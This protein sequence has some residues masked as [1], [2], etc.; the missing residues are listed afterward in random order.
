MLPHRADH[1]GS[2]LR[3]K[4]L[5][6]A[7]RAHSEKSIGD[8]ELRAAQ[9]EAIRDVV[10][11][12]EDCGLQVVTDGEFRRISYWEQFVRLTAGL[13]VRNAVFKFHD[14]AGHESDFTAPYVHSKVSRSAPITV[15]RRD[16]VWPE[17]K[18]S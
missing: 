5:R 4:K 14:Q 9:N 7:F 17:P 12:Q 18:V 2:L 11:L 10:R 15:C 13:E 1:I 16:L 8:A 6:E 3:P